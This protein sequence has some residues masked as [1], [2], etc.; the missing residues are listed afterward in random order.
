MLRRICPLVTQSG[1][2]WLRQVTPTLG[3]RRNDFLAPD[4]AASWRRE[5]RPA[6][7]AVG[8]PIPITPATWTRPRFSRRDAEARHRYASPGKPAAASGPTRCRRWRPHAPQT[9]W[10]L[11]RGCGLY[12]RQVKIVSMDATLKPSD[13]AYQIDLTRLSGEIGA[14][15]SSYC[16]AIE[17]CRLIPRLSLR[18]LLKLWFLTSLWL[19]ALEFCIFFLLIDALLFILR[20]TFGRPHF[21][22]GRRVYA[23]LAKPFRSVWRG[24]IPI[25]TIVRL[26]YL[27]RLLLFYRAQSRI[28]T[29]HSIFNRRH[30]DL[31]FAEPPDDA[32]I[33]KAEKFQKSFDLFQ[34]ITTDSYKIGALAIGGRCPPS[35]HHTAGLSSPRELFMDVFYWTHTCSK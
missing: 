16:D 35:A 33:G 29:L 19:I 7:G 32:S 6:G 22:I 9:F 17:A 18:P 2:C 24:E 15:M 3:C 23:Y 5:A 27:A 12:R 4:I 1:H 10:F 20:R 25:F 21:V 26:R 34:K 28:N 30:L 8:F 31:L 11:G 14:L 13:P